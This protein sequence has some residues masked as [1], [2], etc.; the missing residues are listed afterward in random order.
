M[1]TISA[2]AAGM[3]NGFSYQLHTRLQSYLGET[4]LAEDIPAVDVV[5]EADATLRVPERLTFKVPVTDDQ[6][7]SWVP[8]SYESPLGTYGQTIVAQVGIS[9][10]AGAVEWLNRGTFL[11]ESADTSGDTVAVECAGLLLL[12]DEAV[13]P[14]E[15]QPRAGATLGSI[16]R[17]LIEP[18]ITVDLDDAPTDRVAPSNITWSDNRLDNVYGV[19]DA[20]PAQ[21]TI[22][23]EGNLEVTAVPGDPTVNDVVFVFTDNT[24]GTVTDWNTSITRDGAFNSVYAKG[25]YP[26]TAGTKA[27]QE[28][29]AVAYDS[30]QTSPYRIGGPF[31]PYLVPFGYAS[32]LL[33]TQARANLAASTRLKTLRRTSSKTVQFRAVP[34]P[35]IQLSD[36]VQLT[37]ARLGLSAA[38]GR[39]EAFTLPDDAQGGAMAITAR[40]VG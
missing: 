17:A 22:T 19:L 8:T 5:E 38:L 2:V 39:V 7:N 35:G 20:W 37:S 29:L 34:H 26:D 3:L 13:L 12:L 28:I 30:A 25:Q 27:G 11:V 4:V 21:G 31:S 9:V 33:D 10:A 1:I 6:G 24:G 14:N 36:A 16:L 18:G 40:L 32:P 15:Y 23:A